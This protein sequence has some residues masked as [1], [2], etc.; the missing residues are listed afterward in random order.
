M[1]SGGWVWVLSCIVDKL[2][3]LSQ[4]QL[5]D[6][7]FTQLCSNPA[8][9][10]SCLRPRFNNLICFC[11]LKQ[12]Q[13]YSGHLSKEKSAPICCLNRV[14]IRPS[15]FFGITGFFIRNVSVALVIGFRHQF[16]QIP[17]FRRIIPVGTF[18]SHGCFES[19][20]LI[21]SVPMSLNEERVVF[22]SAVRK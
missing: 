15:S 19:C 16:M 17:A 11:T 4:S 3:T 5:H 10:F 9:C 21:L 6:D 14:V 8:E 22:R 1:V 7:N 2:Q 20:F 18:I 13:L 12:L